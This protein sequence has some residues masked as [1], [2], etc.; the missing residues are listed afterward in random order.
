[1]LP[2]SQAVSLFFQSNRATL[3]KREIAADTTVSTTRYYSIAGQRP[4][5]RNN[6]SS[7]NYLLGDHLGSASTVVNASGQIVSQSRYLPFGELLW[8]DGTSPTDYT[9]T[10]QRSLSDIGLMDYN[11]RFYDPLLGR[12]TSPDSVIPDPGSVIGYNRFAYVNNN[13]MVYTDPS[14]HYIPDDIDWPWGRGSG[15]SSTDLTQLQNEGMNLVLSEVEN[16]V[17]SIPWVRF[18]IMKY[19]AIGNVYDAYKLFKSG[20][21]NVVDLY[22]TASGNIL[23]PNKYI[24]A[25]GN[26]IDSWNH[27]TSIVFSNR[28]LAE[29]LIPI[30]RV[31][32][33]GE[34]IAL[35]IVKP[36]SQ[37]NSL[38]DQMNA[39]EAMRYNQY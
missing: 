16:C 12:F 23:N 34:G 24:D 15:N 13:P 5:I 1:M 9:Y 3:C 39:D 21:R 33:V 25:I 36:P 8:E 28:P 4:A 7:I 6:D 32:K 14:G 10:G 31:T 27:D 22:N 37:M 30:Y 20:N 18:E 19:Q 38:A 11:A 17:T 29:R 35:L 26:S 2:C